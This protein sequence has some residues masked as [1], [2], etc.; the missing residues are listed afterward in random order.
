M[1]RI[2]ILLGSLL[3]ILVSL[4]FFLQPRITQLKKTG[5]KF[6]SRDFEKIETTRNLQ[7]QYLTLK[8]HYQ[9]F[10][11]RKEKREPRRHFPLS[12]A[13]GIYDSRKLMTL[14]SARRNRLEEKAAKIKKRLGKADLVSVLRSLQR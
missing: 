5:L 9:S 14:S 11:G 8:E 12:H 1:K 13:V 4:W 10:L 2:L 6:E 7:G 3:V